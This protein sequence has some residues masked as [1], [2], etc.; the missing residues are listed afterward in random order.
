[1]RSAG[2]PDMACDR[3][4]LLV[5]DQLREPQWSRPSRTSPA[6]WLHGVQSIETG[7]PL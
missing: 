6:T 7:Q 4:R 3:E 5:C 1:M 2:P